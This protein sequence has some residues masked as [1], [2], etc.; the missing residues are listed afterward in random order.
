[1]VADD[2]AHIVDI[3]VLHAE[4]VLDHLGYQLR[5]LKSSTDLIKELRNYTWA[6]D[7][8]GNNL[9]VPIDKWN[10]ALDALRYAAY[11][12]L[13]QEYNYGNYNFSIR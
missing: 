9:N 7:K 4:A 6:K 11:T 3:H 10:H 12:H 1:M 5:V 8:D 2:G 13:A